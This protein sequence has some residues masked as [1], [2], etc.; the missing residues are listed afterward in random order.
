MSSIRTVPLQRHGEVEFHC[1]LAGRVL[2]LDRMAIEQA[3]PRLAQQCQRVGQRTGDIGLDRADLMRLHD[4]GDA[5]PPA[6]DLQSAGACV[7]LT[8]Q[9]L[10]C[11]R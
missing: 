10:P 7:L 9:P 2:Q 6:A 3:Q 1:R 5:H 4:A 8:A 11:R